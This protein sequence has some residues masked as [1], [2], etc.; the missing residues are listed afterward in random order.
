M[1]IFHLQAR[2]LALYKMFS[3]ANRYLF[4]DPNVAQIYL[5]CI[6]IHSEP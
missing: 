3:V 5:D 4:L 6:I 1:Q 2:K